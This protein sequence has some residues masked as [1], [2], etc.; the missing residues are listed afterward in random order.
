MADTS[1]EYSSDAPSFG[2]DG[3]AP[4]ADCSSTTDRVCRWCRRELPTTDPRAV[5]CS[6]RCRQTAFRL[7]R[8]AALDDAP[9]TPGTFCYADPPYPGLSK[10]YYGR[11]ATYAGEVDHA[12]L[13][14]SLEASK[15]A[16][17]ALST[18]ARALQRA[19]LVAVETDPM[20]ALLARR[21]WA[22]Y[23]KR[24]PRKASAP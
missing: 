6:T 13:I 2:D 23:L 17:W 11:E 14:A 5:Y 8:R 22:A 21:T 16:G 9:V 10:R 1:S 7:R 12:A 4:V 18:W 20:S 24:H 19:D 15:Y 3:D